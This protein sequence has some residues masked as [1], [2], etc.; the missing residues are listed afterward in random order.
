MLRVRQILVQVEQNDKEHIIKA[1]SKK[2]NVEIYKIKDFKIHKQSIDA[3][4]KPDL[5][6]IYELDVNVDGEEKILSRCR[7]NDVLLTPKEEYKFSILG[8]NKIK[9]RPI[10]VGSG[11]AGLFAGYMLSK[12]GYMPLI[13]ERGESVD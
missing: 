7:N 5:Y 3:R 12:H 11:P 2:L 8:T 10:I 4:K 13:I 6:Y 9:N 1:C